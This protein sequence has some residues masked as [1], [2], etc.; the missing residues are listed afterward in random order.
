MHVK[1]VLPAVLF[2]ALIGVTAFCSMPRSAGPQRV[3]R[4]E[5]E[6][7]KGELARIASITTAQMS[8]ANIDTEPLPPPVDA[9]EL[10]DLRFELDALHRQVARLQREIAA[11]ASSQSAAVETQPASAGPRSPADFGAQLDDI[12]EQEPAA[13][14]ANR[15]AAELRLSIVRGL[16][17][18]AFVRDLVCRSSLCRAEISYPDLDAY[19]GFVE[20]K[21]AGAEGHIWNGPTFLQ[22]L[23]EPGASRGDVIA[24]VYLAR[25]ESAFTAIGDAAYRPS[26]L[27]N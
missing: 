6:A 14:D 26:P 21:L 9:A 11:Q 25:D 1:I 24:L 7:L 2:S 16:P 19:Q 4:A 8:P 27:P 18:G 12:L 5:L 23:T 17:R 13:A 20:E 10:A 15:L 3:S 22:L